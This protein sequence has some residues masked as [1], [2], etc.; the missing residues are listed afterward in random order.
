MTTH[1]LEEK[2]GIFIVIFG[3]IEVSALVRPVTKIGLKVRS[4][5]THEVMKWCIVCNHSIF[6]KSKVLFHEKWKPTITRNNWNYISD[7]LTKNVRVRKTM[8]KPND[9][10]ARLYF[11]KFEGHVILAYICATHMTITWPLVPHRSIRNL[12]ITCLFTPT[13]RPPIPQTL[14]VLAEFR[15]SEICE[16][17][18][19]LRLYPFPLKGWTS[20][21][22]DP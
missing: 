22:N 14:V 1:K 18:S 2:Y 4:H 9:L 20:L 3:I 8:S 11:N 21:M 19:R 16:K 12:P 10:T 7:W 15:F 6:H 17:K 13:R 5:S